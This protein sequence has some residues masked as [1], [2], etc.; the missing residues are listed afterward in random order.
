M[1]LSHRERFDG[2]MHYRPVDFVPLRM[3]GV[4]DDA[5]ARWER[6]GLPHGADIKARLGIPDLPMANV[7]GETHLWP[8]FE[9]RVLREDDDTI[10][11]QDGYGRTVRQLKGH[12]TTPE[13][14]EHAVKTEADFRRVIEERMS[15]DNLDARY[16]AGW[17][18]S[19]REA[20][21]SDA[22]VMVN[23]GWYFYTL[24]CLVGTEM[25]C[26]LFHDAPDLV[27]EYFERICI[28]ALDGIRR[29]A[30]IGKPDLICFGEDIA[31][32]NGP[33]ISP[34]MNRR[35]L[36]PR[37]A[38]IMDAARAAGCDLA[39][40]GSDGD[41]RLLIPDYLA[42]G[43]NIMEPCEVAAGMVPVE[44]RRR[45]GRD[46]RLMGGIDKREIAKGPRAIDAE[47][48]RNRPVIEEGGFLP[49]VDHSFPAD[50]SFANFCYYVDKMKQ[51][52]RIP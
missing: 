27:D 23:A 41:L 32:K 19:A 37:Y 51:A 3:P 9:S 11:R 1:T 46:L 28:A 29:F 22:L 25:A 52:L 17:A 44:L 49:Y 39:F 43:V 45:F 7:S 14:L 4:L 10:V 2:V 26:C 40:F 38:R 42:V 34:E 21:A 15:V 16:P 48:E 20:A 50:I 8:P 24:N 36:I 13:F 5:R 30:A 33:F 47:I 18:E 6:E 31:Y 35:F 12:N